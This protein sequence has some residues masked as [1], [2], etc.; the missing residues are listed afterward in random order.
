M[1]AIHATAEVTMS[2]IARR[3][4]SVHP[5]LV[6]RSKLGAWLVGLV[7][8]FLEGQFRKQAEV[9]A[10]IRLDTEKHAPLIRSALAKSDEFDED[11]SLFDSFER[12]K[13]LLLS[14]RQEALRT[15]KRMERVPRL[16]D[17][18]IAARQ[19]A[20]VAAE[21]YEAYDDLQSDVAEHGADCAPR[22]SGMTAESASELAALLDKIS[23]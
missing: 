23:V 19:L 15:A 6:P 9:L 3:A 12:M 4:A 18:C 7:P 20:A 17:A 14:I 1:T 2:G 16:R 5:F 21:C 13:E 10:K 8:N 11:L 22:C